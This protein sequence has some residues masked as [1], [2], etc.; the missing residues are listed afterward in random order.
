MFNSINH[1]QKESQGLIDF[2]D[3]KLVIAFISFLTIITLAYSKVSQYMLL[4]FHLILFIIVLPIL[5][6][7]NNN[8]KS[9][10]YGLVALIL[11]ATFIVLKLETIY[12]FAV[13]SSLLFVY[14]S[15]YGK[16]SNLPILLILIISPIT[17][18]FNKVIGFEIR[19]LLTEF[20]SKILKLVYSDIVQMGNQLIVSGNPFTV[21][22]E[23]LGL[24]M[25]I[26]SFFVSIVFL[27]LNEKRTNIKYSTSTVFSVIILSFL[28][29]TISNLFRIILLVVFKSPPNT[30]SHELIG[31]ICF[32]V[33]VVLPLWYLVKLLPMKYVESKEF[34]TPKRFSKTSIAIFMTLIISLSFINFNKVQKGEPIKLDK[35]SIS[36]DT[37][38]YKCSEEELGV[39]KY[40]NNDIL[41]YIKPSAKFYSAEHSPLICWK[42][43]GYKVENEST[44][45]ILGTEIYFCTLTQGDDK[46]FST[47]WYDSGTYKTK[48][49]FKWRKDNLLEGTDYQLVNVISYDK[50]LLISESKRLLGTNLFE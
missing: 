47:W 7:K 16:I 14:E 5:I 4:D 2:L 46:L 24:N 6:S 36:L 40:E 10:R 32:C 35:H 19:L 9:F 8:Q 12:Y 26:M 45:D 31:I 28:L 34:N 11:L 49:Q 15:V 41:I 18:H 42:G 39:L 29:S 3:K 1:L 44:I 21:D 38:N 30:L 23:C 43:S 48:S 27:S 13:I 50:K 33:Y 22:P 37:E 25:M 20:A 17:N